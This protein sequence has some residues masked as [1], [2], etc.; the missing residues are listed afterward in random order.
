MKILRCKVMG[1]VDN[2]KCYDCFTNCLSDQTH[3]S[4]VLCKRINVVEEV[5][6]SPKSDQPAMALEIAAG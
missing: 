6:A 4:R 1:E 3:A 2:M 5:S